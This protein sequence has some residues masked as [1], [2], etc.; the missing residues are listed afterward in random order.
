MAKINQGRYLPAVL[1][2]GAMEVCLIPK[3]IAYD[4][5]RN[6]KTGIEILDPPVMLRLGDNETEVIAT[7]AITAVIRL[8][9]KV[10]ELITR[11]HRCLIWDVPSDEIILGSDFLKRL[12]IDPESALDTLIIEQQKETVTGDT[13]ENRTEGSSVVRNAEAAPFE[14]PIDE[15]E[16]GDVIPE[17]IESSLEQ[18]VRNVAEKGLPKQ[19][20]CKLRNLIKKYSSVWRKSLGPDLPAKVE[21][22]K[23][24]LRPDARPFR[25]KAR[26]YSPEDSE[27]LKKF[28]D[29]LL[30]YGL[31]EENYNSE[32]ALPVL[33]VKKS[34]GG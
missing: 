19:W 20:Q 4:A 13:E 1:D 30:K 3:K 2:S 15:V 28:V 34:D 31:I 14:I 22:F 10:G 8:K 32:W 24:R 5:I 18:L 16:I 26:R 17:E 27:F 23:T 11:E 7:E 25:C 6:N 29:E 12:G 33:V 9:T 21:P